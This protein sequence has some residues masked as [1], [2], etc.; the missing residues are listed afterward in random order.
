MWENG[1]QRKQEIINS[2]KMS[3][4]LVVA[5][6]RAITAAAAVMKRRRVVANVVYVGC[7]LEYVTHAAVAEGH[8]RERSTD[9]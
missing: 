9:L 4:D 1:Q 7:A 2:F 3:E 8:P 5:A 6:T